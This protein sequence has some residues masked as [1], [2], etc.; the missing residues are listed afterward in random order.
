MPDAP[1]DGTIG[2]SD[3]KRTRRQMTGPDRVAIRPDAALRL[4]ASAGSYQPFASLLW[5][6]E[7]KPRA[8]DAATDSRPA[9]HWLWHRSSIARA[10]ETATLTPHLDPSRDFDWQT[11][12][13]VCH[14]NSILVRR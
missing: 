3:A 8:F 9:D 5:L 7:S 1:N 2:R 12:M 14:A 4:A 13:T 11:S 10:P 6:D